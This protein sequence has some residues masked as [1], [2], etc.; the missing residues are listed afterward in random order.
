[1]PPLEFTSQWPTRPKPGRAEGKENA[2][3][4]GAFISSVHKKAM[5]SV[6]MKW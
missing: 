5:M 4:G 6:Q 1:M 2:H 3:G